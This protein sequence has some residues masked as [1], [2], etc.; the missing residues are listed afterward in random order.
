MLYA[1]FFVTGQTLLQVFEL[2]TTAIKKI[3]KMIAKCLYR[4]FVK[5]V[6]KLQ[7]LKQKVQSQFSR[8]RVANT[9]E[10]TE[11]APKKLNATK[12]ARTTEGIGAERE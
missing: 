3:C 9:A 12:R 6:T 1:T 2:L 10:K 8:M 5:V 7:A 11:G 4:L